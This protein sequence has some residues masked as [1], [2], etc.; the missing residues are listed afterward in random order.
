MVLVINVDKLEAIKADD[1]KF[2][3]DGKPAVPTPDE[4]ATIIYTSGTT[5]SAKG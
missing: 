5:G 2:T 3:C 1:E 4:I